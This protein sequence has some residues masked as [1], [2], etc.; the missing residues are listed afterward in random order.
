MFIEDELADGQQKA[1]RY[2]FFQE[3]LNRFIEIKGIE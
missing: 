1:F 3:V 2:R